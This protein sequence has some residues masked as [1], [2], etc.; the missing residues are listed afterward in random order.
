MR[1]AALTFERAVTVAVP[2]HT[3]LDPCLA[4]VSPCPWLQ[5][6]ISTGNLIDTSRF[7]AGF[8]VG[9]ER[10]WL[11]FFRLGRVQVLFNVSVTVASTAFSPVLLGVTRP[12]LR[13]PMCA[14]PN[15]VKYGYKITPHAAGSGISSCPVRTTYCVS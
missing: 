13:M 2:T 10:Q 14:R 15:S 8:R 7:A 12:Q 11:S 1:G 9:G 5:L 4:R 6:V 3:T